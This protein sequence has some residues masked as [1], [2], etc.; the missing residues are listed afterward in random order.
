VPHRLLVIHLHRHHP[1]ARTLRG[2]FQYFSLLPDRR[3][4]EGEVPEVQHAARRAVLGQAA[5]QGEVLAVEKGAR[6]EQEGGA[7]QAVRRHQVPA[8]GQQVEPRRAPGAEAKEQCEAQGEEG[9]VG[10]L[11]VPQQ[12]GQAPDEAPGR[13]G[14]LPSAGCGCPRSR[15]L[16]MQDRARIQSI[17]G[18][19]SK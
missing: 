16:K 2:L 6:G 19:P 7:Q 5:A 4:E 9:G 14:V 3:P 11:A 13:G 17:L 15:D 18:K 8:R 1:Q 12:A 10:R